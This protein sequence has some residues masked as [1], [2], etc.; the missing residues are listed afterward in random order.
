MR[1]ALRRF[2]W[3]ELKY[4]LWL[5]VY[6][7]F[8]FV[9]ERIVVT[10][11]WPT[12][13]WLDGKI[14]F[15]EWFVIPYCLWYPLLVAVGLWLLRKDREGFRRYMRFLAITFFLSELIWLL[16]PN[17]QD[18]R[19]AVMPRDHLL[20]RLVAEL[21]AIDTN[22]NVFPSVHVVGAIGAAWAVWKT[23]SLRHRPAIRR[24]VAVLAALICLSTLFI[25]QHAVLDAASGLGLALAVGV[26]L[27]SSRRLHHF[28]PAIERE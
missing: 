19:P 10:G 2:P 25:K 1:N 11:Y 20:T 26:P 15:C 7:L 21:Y 4:V 14:P 13:T 22:T 9:I 6:L 17:G 27:Y 24:A 3:G 16:V 8:F 28:R 18:L 23:P 5:P 12:Q